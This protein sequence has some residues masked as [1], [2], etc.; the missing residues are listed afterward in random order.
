[1]QGDSSQLPCYAASTQH[2]PLQH[3]SC[4]DTC[5]AEVTSSTQTTCTNEN[6]YFYQKKKNYVHTENIHVL[7]LIFS[8]KKINK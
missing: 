3:I 1:M 5:T 6:T 2:P 8:A 7:E 4:G